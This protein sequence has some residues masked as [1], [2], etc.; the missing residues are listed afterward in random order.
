MLSGYTTLLR[1][2]T[3]IPK[4]GIE[5]A[6]DMTVTMVLQT[7]ADPFGL[8]GLAFAPKR[9]ARQKAKSEQLNSLKT[10]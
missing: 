4:A 1:Q 8:F 2:G 6:C 10:S 5:P 7:T 9:K 3:L